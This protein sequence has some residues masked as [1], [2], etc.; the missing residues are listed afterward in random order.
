LH[1]PKITGL[2][3]CPL[4]QLDFTFTSLFTG[5]VSGGQGVRFFIG[6]Y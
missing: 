5:F 2:L 3:N 4:L 1:T 6:Q